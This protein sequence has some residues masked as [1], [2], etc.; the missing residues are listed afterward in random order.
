ME[1]Y[2]KNSKSHIYSALLK[3]GY[4]NFSLTILEYCDK[5]KCLER[6][7]FYL[8]SLQH[9]YNIAKKAGAPMY[10]RKHSDE[11][12]TIMSDA[13]KKNQHSFKKG[14]PRPEGSG[15]P[16]QAIE[17][18]DITNN[19]KISFISMREAAI[20]L[21]INKSVFSKYFKRN[22]NK[23]YKGRYTFKKV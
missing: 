15:S 12:K 14:Q 23:P 18:T 22:Q 4:S 3:H 13:Q 1:N 21:N 7:D 6:E 5:E 20:A 19:T 16:S 2:L 11:N 17:V 8:S 10:G 9:E